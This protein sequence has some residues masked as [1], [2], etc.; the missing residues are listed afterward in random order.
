M[1]H[2]EP[3]KRSAL[4]ILQ[5]YSIPLLGGV[6]LGLLWANVAP[7][8]YHAAMHWEPFGHG[9]HFNLHFFANEILMVFFFG[10]AAKEITEACLPGGA[11][12]PPR[13]AV[14]PLMGTLGG[15]L[16]PVGVYFIIATLLGEPTIYRGWGIP[17]AT[18]IA[19]AWLVA[20]LVFGARHPAV[21][22]L[23]L[24][25]VA[26]DA[27]GLAIIAV[28][29]PDPQNPVV[30]SWAGLVL[31]AM[32]IA[33]VMRKRRVMSFWPY[34]LVPGVLSWLGLLFAHLHPALALVPIVPFMPNQG[35]DLGLYAERGTGT[36]TLNKFE[37]FFKRPV[38]FGLLTFGLANA[39]VEMSSVGAAT[40][41]V[42]GA[43][44]IGKTTGITLFSFVA[45]KAG[46]TLP[47]G[48]TPKILVLA[49][50]VA[51]IGLT[52]ALFVAGVAFT[53]ES[54]QGAA[55]MGALLSSVAAPLALVLGKV[56]GVKKIDEGEEELDLGGAEP[57]GEH[58]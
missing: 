23:L 29:Y 13:K 3:G 14:N 22:F 30:L 50:L 52:V 46:F 33:F 27:A 57:S 19:L 36:D 44:L 48:M 42:A 28:F 54:L 58:R 5:E 35:T 16:G 47:K 31:L 55:K 40:W 49:G 41:T 25:A 51:G 12:N 17:T 21:S 18:D 26:D 9:S 15:I 34:V 8:G 10:V 6:L 2:A 7:H 43:L 37:H 20:R 32:V 56:L 24:L 38:D 11:L 53:D 1:S 4:D 45:D 39:G